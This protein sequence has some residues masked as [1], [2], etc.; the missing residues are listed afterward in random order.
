[1][2]NLYHA[3][4]MA[5]AAPAKLLAPENLLQCVEVALLVV[6]GNRQDGHARLF[7]NFLQL[8]PVAGSLLSGSLL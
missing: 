1:M 6:V 2:I 4:G 7:A 5:R 8:V 3:F